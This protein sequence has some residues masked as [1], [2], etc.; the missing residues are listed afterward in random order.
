MLCVV[1]PPA[2]SLEGIWIATFKTDNN[3][4]HKSWSR[5]KSFVTTNLGNTTQTCTTGYN[6][7]EYGMLTSCSTVR[8]IQNLFLTRD[9]T[10]SR[11]DV[12]LWM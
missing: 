9:Q 3:K 7:Y 4:T 2:L 5:S 8:Q 6:A 10:F 1:L 12:S 11:V